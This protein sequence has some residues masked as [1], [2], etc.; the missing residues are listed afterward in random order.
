MKLFNGALKSPHS[1]QEGIVTQKKDK[2]EKKKGK[3][4]QSKE[5]E[6]DKNYGNKRV[7]CVE[8]ALPYIYTISIL[9]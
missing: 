2:N 5:N 3:C 8:D 4:K 1:L 7:Y 9:L 6:S